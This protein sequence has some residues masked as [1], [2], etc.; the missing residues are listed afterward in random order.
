MKSL[1]NDDTSSDY[2]RGMIDQYDASNHRVIA[3]T[4]LNT[5]DI[6]EDQ[7]DH[8]LE[9]YD[10]M[11]NFVANLDPDAVD[12]EKIKNMISLAEDLRGMDV[13]KKSDDKTVQELSDLLD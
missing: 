10:G 4:S 1:L 6:E 8:L 3:Y 5:I 11:Q 12:E 9:L 7:E 2:T 13:T